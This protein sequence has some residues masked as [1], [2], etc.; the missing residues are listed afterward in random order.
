M[1]VLVQQIAD[2][3]V[4]SVSLI[5]QNTLT[6]LNTDLLLSTGVVSIAAMHSHT[7]K[8]ILHGTLCMTVL[9]TVASVFLLVQCCEYLHLF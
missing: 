7:M 6:L 1:A 8:N 4:D 3:G 9:V 2:D 5:Y